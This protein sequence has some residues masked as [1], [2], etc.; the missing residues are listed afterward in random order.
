MDFAAE[1]AAKG[2]AAKQAAAKLAVLPT[3]GKNKALLA[4]ADA[5][6]AES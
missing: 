2:A 6:E 3:T 4:M 5:L 1:L